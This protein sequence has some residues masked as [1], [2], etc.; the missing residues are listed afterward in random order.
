MKCLSSLKAQMLDLNSSS[1]LS[2][3]MQVKVTHLLCIY[4]V[5]YLAMSFPKLLLKKYPFLYQ[6]VPVCV[7][8]LS[9]FFTFKFWVRT[10]VTVSK[11]WWPVCT[12]EGS[13][14]NAVSNSNYVQFFCCCWNCRWRY[15]D[16]DLKKKILFIFIFFII[17][18]GNNTFR[19]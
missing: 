19:I 8:T 11:F 4:L 15:G 3:Q 12:Y 17:I 18:I 6:N 5:C 7:C 2:R 13:V 16:C 14:Q 10:Y 9:Q 1:A